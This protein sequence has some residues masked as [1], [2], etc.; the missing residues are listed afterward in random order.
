M[1]LKTNDFSMQ[2][3]NLVENKGGYQ[4]LDNERW[5]VPKEQGICLAQLVMSK[6]KGLQARTGGRM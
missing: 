3:G 4:V 6:R 2:G 1:S 5:R